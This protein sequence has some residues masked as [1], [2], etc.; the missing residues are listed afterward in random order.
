M[1]T[2]F[3]DAE[4]ELGESANAELEV[5]ARPKTGGEITMRYESIKE[6]LEDWEDE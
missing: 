3:A 4:F 6:L 1:R 5:I 2:K